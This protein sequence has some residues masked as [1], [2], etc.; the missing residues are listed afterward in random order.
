MAIEL[1]STFKKNMD[2]TAEGGA[3]APTFSLREALVMNSQAVDGTLTKGGP[4][5]VFGMENGM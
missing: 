1:G 5:N 4:E 3:H 2:L